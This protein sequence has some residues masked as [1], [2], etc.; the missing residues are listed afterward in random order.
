MSNQKIRIG[1][2]PEHFN[3]PWKFALENN[4][5]LKQNIEIEWFYYPSGTGSMIEAIRNKKLDIAIMLT[6][7]AVASICNGLEAKIIKQYITSPLIWGI[8]TGK[9]STIKGIGES[10]D[11]I[12]SISRFNSGSHLMAM[13]ESH[14]RQSEINDSQWLI[15]NNLNQSIID[16]NENKADLFFWEKYTTKPF[17]DKGEINRISEFV[18]P[19][20]C[21]QMVAD[22]DSINEKKDEIMSVLKIINFVGKQFM[23][24]DNSIDL[25]IENYNM[26]PED[27]KNWFYSTEWNTD[28]DI[29]EK[30][31]FNVLFSLKSL[32]VIDNCPN[33]KELIANWVELY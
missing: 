29:S 25:I 26:L 13:L 4:I 1:G 14:I 23:T 6:E 3:Y 9:F 24:S 28:F 27:A 22:V 31:L 12:Y 32:N 5:F 10:K 16:L 7:G 11:K 18:T 21:F 20:S 8:H 33:P 15:S 30:M 19:W 17:V 2:V